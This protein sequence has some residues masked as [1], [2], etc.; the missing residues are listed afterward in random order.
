MIYKQQRSS[1][2]NHKQTWETRATRSRCFWKFLT[3]RRTF[4]VSDEASAADPVAFPGTSLQVSTITS[5]NDDTLEWD[6]DE[7]KR[8]T[9]DLSLTPT[10]THQSIETYF[11]A[12]NTV[13]YKHKREGYQLFKDDYVKTMKF[14]PNVRFGEKTFFHL[15]C[16]VTASMRRQ[17]V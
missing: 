16:V 17:S 4:F 3:G 8:W 7:S 11:C 13:A 5:N 2:I 15:S 14:M 1:R 6:V 12:E 10:V 9:R